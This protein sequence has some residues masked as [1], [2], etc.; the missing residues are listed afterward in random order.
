MI[1]RSIF[2]FWILAKNVVRPACDSKVALVPLI[3]I[4]EATVMDVLIVVILIVLLIV[5]HWSMRIFEFWPFCSFNSKGEC[6]KWL[7][8]FEFDEKVE[9]LSDG[10]TIVTWLILLAVPSYY[11]YSGEITLTG[12]S[13]KKRFW[14]F[15]VEVIIAGLMFKVL[16][17][18]ADYLSP[19]ILHRRFNIVS[20]QHVIESVDPENSYDI[21]I[22]HASEDKSSVAIPLTQYL[23]ELGLKVWLDEFELKIGDSLRSNIEHGLKCSRFGVVVLSPNYFQKSWTKLELGALLAGGDGKEKIL[24]VWHNITKEKIYESA[25][26][27]ADKV[28]VHTKDGI[29]KVAKKIYAKVKGGNPLITINESTESELYRQ[30]ISSLE[31]HAPEPFTIIAYLLRRLFATPIGALLFIIGV[32]YFIYSIFS[33]YSSLK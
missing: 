5:F 16:G 33:F 27:L 29:D 6:L 28:A 32:I 26:L 10:V 9:K 4:F 14:L 15:I 21:F 22:S 13:Q 25:P 12:L 1:G 18:C 24:P 17:R 7:S 31:G 19:R 23:K 3:T 30:V 11:I 2:Q 8:Q 20:V